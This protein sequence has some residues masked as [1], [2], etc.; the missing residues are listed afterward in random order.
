MSVFSIHVIGNDNDLN[1]ICVDRFTQHQT[2]N[3]GPTL[4]KRSTYNPS[5]SSLG[6]AETSNVIQPSGFSRDTTRMSCKSLGPVPARTA[7]VAGVYE[8]SEGKLRYMLSFYSIS[9]SIAEFNMTELVMS[10]PEEQL[11]EEIQL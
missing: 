10:V 3:R 1:N 7:I 9:L 5:P 11:F 4:S 2:V 6:S 8:S